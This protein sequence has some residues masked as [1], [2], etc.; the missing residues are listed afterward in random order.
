LP[1]FKEQVSIL[2]GLHQ[3]SNKIE[4]SL[5]LLKLGKTEINRQETSARQLP[6]APHN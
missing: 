6:K 4:F 1:R 5:Y 3:G 2:A